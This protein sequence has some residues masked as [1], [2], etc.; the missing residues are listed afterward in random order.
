MSY[1]QNDHRNW[2]PDS[3]YLIETP[4][5]MC[6]ELLFYVQETGHFKAS[7][8][9]FT[10][11][12]NYPSYLLKFTHS[13]QGTLFYEGSTYTLEKN[14]F[15]LIDCKRYQHYFTSSNEPWEMDWIHFYGLGTETFYNYFLRSGSNK[16]QSVN[17]KIPAIIQKI[18]NQLLQKSGKSEFKV[19][20]LI[21]ELL[22]EV[23]LNKYH[24]N[25]FEDDIPYHIK[26]IRAY[27]EANL[28]RTV[29]LDEL[30][31]AFN[32]DKFHLSKEFTKFQ[33]VPPIEYH[34]LAKISYAKELLRFTSLSMKEISEVIGIKNSSYFSRLFK[35]RTGMTP[36]N[37]RKSD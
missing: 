13:G 20:L 14:S 37:Y 10:E 23:I 31:T 17:S 18:Q 1:W 8:P 24:S 15:F 7:K 6:K 29:T 35:K 21:H 9:Y 11:R 26:E 36:L 30:A 4:S 19:S 25:D 3:L 32:R 34:L 33:G 27:L 28:T 16:C 12:E 5:Q 22:N 2:S